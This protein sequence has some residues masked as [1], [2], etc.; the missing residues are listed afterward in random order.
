MKMK[1]TFLGAAGTVTGSRHL[2]TEGNQKILIDC[3]LFQGGKELQQRNWE[4]FPL[5]PSSIKAILLT[6]AHIDHSGYI[7][8]LVRDGFKGKVYCSEATYDL[9][10]ILLP[11][12]GRIAE[13]DAAYAN[14][15]H[16]S[17]HEPALP[18]YTEHDAIHALDFFEVIDFGQAHPLGNELECTFYRAGH[19]LGASFI[20]VREGDGTSVL[21]SGDIGRLTDVIMKSPAQIQEADY[22]VLESTYGDRLHGTS[23]PLEQL[24]QILEKTLARGGSL[25][26]P[27]FAVG[28]SQMMLYYLYQLKKQGRLPHNIPIYLDSPMA[29]N[30]TE[31]L[32]KHM[33]DHHLSRGLC[34]EICNI[35]EYTRTTAESK[36][37]NEHR[38]PKIILSA[39]GMLTGGRILH[40]VRNTVSDPRNTIL[41]TG[42][43]ASGTIGA[44]LLSGVEEVKIHGMV[45]PV[46]AEIIQLNNLSAHADYA[47]ILKWLENFQKPPRKVFIV[48]GEPVPAQ[49]MKENIIERFGWN[50]YVPEYQY[51][52][53]L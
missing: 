25:V 26:I 31:L 47:E 4:P 1:I 28:R 29:I 53:D 49:A 44:E 36:A 27:S 19:I 40:H 50:V 7:P 24:G 15:H 17:S 48:H 3:G 52:E 12:S 46:Q 33:S 22:I 20:R 45:F 41:L 13:E 14:L 21:F 8:K 6:H 37:I 10:K 18:L 42:F 30:V 9:C 32:H 2:I 11:D 51:S 16:Y 34:A 43:Q 35:A 39:S 23:D 38:V 5:E